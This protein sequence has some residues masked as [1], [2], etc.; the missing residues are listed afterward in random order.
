MVEN[1]KNKLLE[2][3]KQLLKCSVRLKIEAQGTCNSLG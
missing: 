3:R 1:I 2:K